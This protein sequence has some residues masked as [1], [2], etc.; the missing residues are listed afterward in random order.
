[1]NMTEFTIEKVQ[2]DDFDRIG[3]LLVR[4]YSSL[5]GFPKPDEQP[6]YY[7]MLLNVGDLTLVPTTEILVAKDSNGK[8]I[9][10]VVFFSDMKHYGSGGTAVHEKNACGFR[11]L[12]VDPDARGLGVGKALSMACIERA[13]NLGKGK[14]VIHST[15]A[16]KV[17][18]G[19]YER[20]GFERALD[21]DFMQQKLKVYGFR[22]ILK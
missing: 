18:W 22:L 12:A 2:T 3:K 1:M 19:M 5:D 6:D 7:R 15:E 4:V 10:A 21:L 16:M 13:R 14:V 17:A 8:N 20:L 11:L 9:G